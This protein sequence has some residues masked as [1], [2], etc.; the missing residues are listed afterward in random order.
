MFTIDLFKGQHIPVKSGPRST[1]VA[2]ATIVMPVVIAI[3]VF[4]CYV[5]GKSTIAR[6]KQELTNCQLKI[7]KLAD[8]VSHLQ[9]IEKDEK[10]INNCLSEVS[11]SIDRHVS[12]SPVLETIVSNLP[13]SVILTR[14][15]VKQK[16]V[17]KKVAKGKTKKQV[18]VPVRTL[19]MNIIGS[20]YSN[21]DKA[22]RDFRDR[23]RFSSLLKSRIEDITVS[24]GFG[25]LGGQNIVSYDV[26]CIFKS[27]L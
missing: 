16:F 9:S 19:K 26:S 15:D 3:I 10:Q 22:V 20:P 14:L 5:Y 23:L 17:R 25:V 7:N 12:W 6:K 1:A 4:G 27:E 21:S 11:S 24:Q 2:V 8:A 18:T 13:D